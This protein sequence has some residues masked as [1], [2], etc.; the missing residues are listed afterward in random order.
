MNPLG[1]VVSPNEPMCFPPPRG[2]SFHLQEVQIL[3]GRIT[4][5]KREGAAIPTLRPF[6]FG[7]LVRFVGMEASHLLHVFFFLKVVGGCWDHWFFTRKRNSYLHTL[8]VSHLLTVTGHGNS[9]LI[10]IL[11]RPG[12]ATPA[13]GSRGSRRNSESTAAPATF[14]RRVRAVGRKDEQAH[15]FGP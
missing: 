13:L 3:G 8:G 15:P 10:A 4:T 5:P 9:S 1:P 7:L 12:L 14:E 2:S 11:Q 6:L